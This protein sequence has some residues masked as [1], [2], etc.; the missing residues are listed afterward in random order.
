MTFKK[1]AN[2]SFQMVDLI[3]ACTATLHSQHYLVMMLKDHFVFKKTD[4]GEYEKKKR[5]KKYLTLHWVK[6][7]SEETLMFHTIQKSKIRL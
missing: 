2:L 4:S 1:S 5:G 7:F 6:M 3:K